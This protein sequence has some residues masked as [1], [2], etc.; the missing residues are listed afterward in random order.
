[1]LFSTDI[2][3]KFIKNIPLPERFLANS[4]AKPIHN[5]TLEGLSNSFDKKGY[6]TAMELPLTIDGDPPAYLEANSP[7]RITYFDKTM[8]K[9]TKE[10]V[11]QLSPITKPFIGNFNLNGI[12]DILEFKPNHFFVIERI[13]QSGY[14]S[15]GNIVR[16]YHAY[17]DENTTNSLALSSLK[18]GNFIPMKKE[19]VL[20][21]DI[22]KNELTENIVDNIE[23]I[24]FG[25][26]LPNGNKTLLFVSDDNFQVYGKQLNQ[27]ILF[28]L[29]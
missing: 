20:D 6:W 17:Y 5:K 16:V 28:E 2:R 29:K 18:E 1:L 23:G 21:F 19:L 10:F 15:Y 9:A 25:P 14:G 26:T 11:Y 12:T 3:G 13:Y 8:E 4:K 27:V 7:I 24:T 22:I